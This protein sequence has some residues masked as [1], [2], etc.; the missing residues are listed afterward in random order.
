MST[1]GRTANGASSTSN[2]ADTK[3]VSSASPSTSGKVLSATARC[4]VQST[5]TV[6]KAV[7]Y[8]D[9][10]GAPTTLLATS[11]ELSITGTSE[12]AR[13]FTFSGANQ[14]SITAGTTYWIGLI[15]QDPGAS[16][17]LYSR[18]NTANLIQTNAD[19]Y[20]DGPASS[21]GAPS[22]AN[23]ALD[24][25]ITYESVKW[26]TK[27]DNFDDNSLDGAFWSPWVAGDYVETGQTLQITSTTASS[28]KGGEVIGTGSLIASYVVLEVEHV[29]TGLTDAGTFLQL[30]LNATNTLTFFVYG[31]TLTAE[32][33][34]A[35]SF[36]TV[37]TVAYNATN[38]RW[39]RIREASGTI[40]FDTS[41]DG[42][43]WNNFTSTTVTF[44]LI[45][46]V[47]SLFI[48]T[49]SANGGTDTA[50][51]DN[52]NVLP[53]SG[54]TYTNTFTI[55]GIV[56]ITATKIFTVDGLIKGTNLKQFTIDGF[57]VENNTQSFTVDG[58][59][60]ITPAW[61]SK[62]QAWMDVGNSNA[63]T[64]Y[65]DGRVLNFLKPFYYYLHTDGTLIQL[66]SGDGANG[67]SEANA[68]DVK[69]NSR[70][71]YFTVA[72]NTIAD[73]RQLI[74]N[75]TKITAFLNT[76]KSLLDDTSFDGVDV[77]F[78]DFWSWNDT[79]Y[80]NYKA[81]I[82]SLGNHLHTYGYNLMVDIPGMVDATAE[83]D[84][85]IRIV[86]YNSL[87]VDYVVCMAYDYQYEFGAGNPVA[88]NTWVEGICDYA[89][90]Q[91]TDINKLVIGIPS[92]GYHGTTD[93][94]ADIVI[95]TKAQ[96]SAYT[97]YDTAT[98]DPDSYEMMWA[99]AGNSYVY[100]DTEGLNAKRTLIE[101]TGIK[102]VSVWVLGD[103]DW[104]TGTE[105]GDTTLT[106]DGLVIIIPTELTFTV[107]GIVREQFSEQITM[108]GL[109]LGTQVKTFTVDGVV[110]VTSTIELTADGIILESNTS[111]FTVDGI[112]LVQSA[113][114]FTT[115][116]II[117]ASQD[118]NFTVDGII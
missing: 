86:D 14:I 42:I 114:Q 115:D 76:V 59:I 100:Q 44:A 10:G 75:S 5:A 38:H 98:R 26:Q 19:T 78:E 9:S 108:D 21:F 56:L 92:Y 93:E 113:E 6:A 70:H 8:S 80:T 96:S 12:G 29:L 107:D 43:T 31:T 4:W 52:F 77:D 60:A 106:V 30:Y 25:F 102:Y 73:I 11:D 20:S 1:F 61:L 85:K 54:D 41:A 24:A 71:Q 32:K 94:T 109:V 67:Y 65:Q 89:I 72:G 27:Q 90:S 83:A 97:G 17:F 74:T 51:F 35:S 104:F 118:L 34:V 49:D 2:S 23:G 45:D 40:Y 50:V 84:Q 39:W 7:I 13:I 105:I 16:N 116:G 79:D 112:V 18:A 15:W 69:A 22:A 68:V 99:N 66:T 47:A 110:L 58:I 36:T 62:A 103:N 46:L 48:G 63:T 111:S 82:T 101:A 53:P 64:E 33:Q 91:L 81:F 87:P 55:D 88:P 37:A 117:K 95:D 3:A 28:Y 57:I